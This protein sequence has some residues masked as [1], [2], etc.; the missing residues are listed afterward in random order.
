MGNS[1]CRSSASLPTK[2][3]ERR[4]HARDMR[5]S[6]QI[7][8][9]WGIPVQIHWT[10]LLVFAW[11][12]YLQH[13]QAWDLG[14]TLWAALLVV[15]LFS[16]V[17]LHEFG[18]A[19]TARRFGVRT[20]D[21]ILSPIGGIARLDRLPDKPWQELLVAIAGP[22]VNI[23]IALALSPLVIAS[24]PL[25]GQL[26]Q[27]LYPGS[28][29]FLFQLNPLEHFVFWLFFLNGILALFNLI[30]AFPMDGGRILRAL[31]SV[32]LG[33]M[34]ATR[35]AAYIGQIL[36]VLFMIYGWRDNSLFFMAI[37]FFVFITAMGEYRAVK[38]DELLASRQVREAMRDVFTRIYRQDLMEKPLEVLAHGSERSFLVFDKWQNLVGTLGEEALR[39]AFRKK[40]F[41]GPVNRYS[42]DGYESLRTDDNLE[43]AVARLRDCPN[44]VLPVF[45]S[46]QCLVGL[47]DF[48]LVNQFVKAGK[49]KNADRKK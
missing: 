16:C 25:R 9:I 44:G 38:I 8:N 31:L 34:Q 21:I 26:R 37:G 22:L 35:F 1:I 49:I 42:R 11:L 32:R 39:E 14:H 18:H 7:A 5:G 2:N 43:S 41:A 3:T 13:T 19:L 46:R 27:L 30:P 36:A 6:I 24:E 12:L 15:A 29:V 40:D 10:F 17:L 48:Q 47:L 20:H 45:D 23:A 33:R 28:N 4:T